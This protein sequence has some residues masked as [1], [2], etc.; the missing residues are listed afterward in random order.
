MATG[1]PI[2]N[3]HC[4]PVGGFISALRPSQLARGLVRAAALGIRQGEDATPNAP[5]HRTG[6]PTFSRLFFTT[7][8]NEAGVPTTVIG[9][10]PTG[11]TSLYLFFDYSNMVNGMVYELRVTLD[12][13]PNTR[14][15]LP[16]SPGAAASAACGI[17]AAPIRPGKTGYT[18]SGC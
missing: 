7:R 2:R 17:S 18:A 8:I 12:D 13:V 14:H 16:P 11:A 3:D 15:S 5:P 9:G 1:A 10:L 6:N 4:V